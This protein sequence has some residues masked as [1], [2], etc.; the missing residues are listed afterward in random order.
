M[1]GKGSKPEAEVLTRLN[2]IEV[3][4]DANDSSKVSMLS[5]AKKSISIT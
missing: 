2:Q 1:G 3:G 4:N 5:N